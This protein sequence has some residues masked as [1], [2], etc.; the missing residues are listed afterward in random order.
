MPGPLGNGPR[1]PSPLWVSCK[2]GRDIIRR[3][4]LKVPGPIWE[5]FTSGQICFSGLA[6]T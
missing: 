1:V 3:Q 6:K 4:R 2:P 5:G